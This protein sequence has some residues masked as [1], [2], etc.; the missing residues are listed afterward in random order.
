MGTYALYSMRHATRMVPAWYL[1]T[2]FAIYWP[3]T[4]SSLQAIEFASTLN[5]WEPEMMQDHLHWAQ[6]QQAL[7]DKE[8][9]E[10][11]VRLGIAIA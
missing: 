6:N 10:V 1:A 9:W 11:Q 3:G 8:Q 4:T 2:H 5:G 7:M